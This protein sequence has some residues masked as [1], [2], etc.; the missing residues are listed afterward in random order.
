MEGRVRQFR[1]MPLVRYLGSGTRERENLEFRVMKLLRYLGLG[2][3]GREIL[4]CKVMQLLRYLGLGTWQREVLE[5]RVMQSGLRYLGSLSQ[6]DLFRDPSPTAFSFVMRLTIT[7]PKS[8]NGVVIHLVF[9]CIAPR[10]E[11]NVPHP[12]NY[13]FTPC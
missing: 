8:L 13:K 11:H 9:L 6:L 10:F 2:T 7:L 5:F 4:E 3:W 1:V 12:S